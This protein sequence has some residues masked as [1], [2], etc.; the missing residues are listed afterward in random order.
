MTDLNS[1]VV[2]SRLFNCDM[3]LAILLEEPKP[4]SL[5]DSFA[6]IIYL[7]LKKSILDSHRLWLF[8]RKRTESCVDKPFKPKAKNHFL[9]R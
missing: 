1:Q 8:S 5:L 9:F 3:L 2:N 4:V 6:F 7:N